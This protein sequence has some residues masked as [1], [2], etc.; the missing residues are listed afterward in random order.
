MAPPLTTPRAPR[1]PPRVRSPSKAPTPS[2]CR[3]VVTRVLLHLGDT[4]DRERGALP[5]RRRLV[6]RN[7]SELG[8]GLD[9]QQLDLQPVPQARLVGPDGGHVGQAVSR[10]HSLRP[11]AR[12]SLNF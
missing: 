1:T 5:N 12:S 2:F 7:A 9:R 3:K 10:D 6:R 11:S 8:P 4:I